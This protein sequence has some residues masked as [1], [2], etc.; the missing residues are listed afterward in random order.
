MELRVQNF[1][2]FLAPFGSLN[3]STWLW[4]LALVC[5]AGRVK[6][7]GGLLPIQILEGPLFKYTYIAYFSDAFNIAL[8]VNSYSLIWMFAPS[9]CADVIINREE[10]RVG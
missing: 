9:Y 4:H 8:N 5:C 2:F 10:S 7:F 6:C 3:E 1:F